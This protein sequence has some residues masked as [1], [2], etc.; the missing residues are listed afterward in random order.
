MST[1]QEFI[2]KVAQAHSI[3]DLAA[4]FRDCGHEQMDRLYRANEHLIAHGH[5]V[6]EV[7]ADLVVAALRGEASTKPTA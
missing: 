5:E 3:K 1:T 7:S 6:F 4:A 2:A